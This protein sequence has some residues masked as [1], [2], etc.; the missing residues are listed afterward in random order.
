MLL[1][2][3]PPTKADNAKNSQGGKGQIEDPFIQGLG[4]PLTQ[5]LGRS[6]AD[7]ALGFYR[8]RGGK[9]KAQGQY[10]QPVLFYK[11]ILIVRMIHNSG[12]ES[13][14]YDY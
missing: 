3:L 10:N 4:G 9:K 5:L 13:Q 7:G 6:G 14:N 8:G 1:F 12:V 2:A 11:E